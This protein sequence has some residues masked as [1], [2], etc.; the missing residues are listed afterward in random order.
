MEETNRQK[1]I[2]GVLQKDLIDILQGEARDWL[3]GV[4]I[5]VTKVY[6]TSDLG[7]AKI[8]VSVFPSKHRDKMLE[9][10]KKNSSTIRYELARR[11][12]NQL[13]RMPNLEFFS[14]DSLDYIEGIDEALKGKDEN[15]IKNPDILPK[16]QKR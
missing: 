13:R 12:K 15:P 4:L 14:D 3:K 6:V 10:I 16:R 2:A 11:T 7:E 8:Y 5:S 9:G 1:K